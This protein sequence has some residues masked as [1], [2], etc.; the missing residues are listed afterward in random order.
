MIYNLKETGWHKKFVCDSSNIYYTINQDTK[1][2]N[3]FI[4]YDNFI[5]LIEE[6]VFI[7]NA[8]NFTSVI[9]YDNLQNINVEF[10]YA[11]A[12]SDIVFP[13]TDI[14]CDNDNG[15]LVNTF[16]CYLDSECQNGEL[17]FYDPERK[18]STKS[19]ST[20][21]KKC[22]IFNGDLLH[23]PSPIANGFRYAILFQ[24]PK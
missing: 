22:I 4:A 2:L 20:N 12:D 16:I 13:W 6:V 5:D 1:R 3:E 19:S 23:N 7:M 14:H 18:I 9:D 15:I 8:Y 17:L 21:E 10:H 11:N 24:I